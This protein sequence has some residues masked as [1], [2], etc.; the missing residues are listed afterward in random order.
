MLLGFLFLSSL[1]VSVFLYLKLRYLQERLRLE[2][3][4]TSRL[5]SEV[6]FYRAT[7][8]STEAHLEQVY[9]ELQESRQPEYKP[10]DDFPLPEPA[11]D[12][13]TYIEVN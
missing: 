10:I 1:A 4:N 5:V 9:L 8:R 2:V 11:R 13:G 7:L 12:Q 6:Q 3:L